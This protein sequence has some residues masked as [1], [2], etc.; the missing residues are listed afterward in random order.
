MLDIAEFYDMLS[1]HGKYQ[2]DAETFVVGCLKLK[3][4]ASSL[5]LQGLIVSQKRALRTLEC[6]VEHSSRSLELIHG[7][8]GCKAATSK[9][10]DCDIPLESPPAP[11]T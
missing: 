7:A 6:L 11:V 2:V 5:D 3:G 4:T 8:F 1:C 10:S 9:T